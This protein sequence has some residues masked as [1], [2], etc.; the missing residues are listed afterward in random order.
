[1]PL[2]SRI[3]QGFAR[4]LE[5]LP[6][7][8][9]QLLLLAAAE[10]VGDVTLLRRAAELLGL[11]ADEAAPAEAAGLINIGARVRFRHPLVRS[12]AYR[13]ASVPDRRDV[14]RALAE[15]TDPQLDPDRRAWH[16]AHAAARFD[17]AVAGELERS[18]GRARSRGGVAA[19]AAF[20]AARGGADPRSGPARPAGAGRRPGQVRVGGAGGRA[21]ARGGCG[22]VPTGRAAERPAG[23]PARTVRVRPDARHR[24]SGPPGRRRQTARSA[25][26]RVGAPDVPRGARIGDV[27]RDAS[28]PTPPCSR[29]PAPRPRGRSRRDRSTS[30]STDWQ[31][32][33]R[34]DRPRACRCS[35]SRSSNT[36]TKRSMVTRRSS[37]GSC[38]LRSSS[39]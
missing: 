5:P 3:E 37:A 32:G 26:S 2:I 14:H 8:T 23:P 1:M 10:P 21:G 6:G 29:R 13:A 4:Q 31:R 28:M 38:C 9:R 12:A 34:R 39:R 16:R 7:E 33:A 27:R 24:R 36:P 20:L 15:A 35:G 19:A 30:C 22:D 18:A 17:E 11:E 25:R